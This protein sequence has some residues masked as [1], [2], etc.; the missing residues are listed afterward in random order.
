MIQKNECINQPIRTAKRKINL[1]N[2]DSLRQHQVYQYSH[3]N[4]SRKKCGK[5]FENAFDETMAEKFPKLKKETD[6]H[7][8]EAQKVPNKMVPHRPT[9]RHIIIK[10]TKVKR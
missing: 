5:G 7:V 9:P 6:N 1:K 3:Y 2:E 8:Q 10:T 4:G